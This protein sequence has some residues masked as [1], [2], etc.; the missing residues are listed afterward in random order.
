MRVRLHV[1]GLPCA[2]LLLALGACS[3]G[4][5]GA[6]GAPAAARSYQLVT[7]VRPAAPERYFDA[8]YALHTM[9]AGSAQARGL[10]VTPFPTF[11]K[12]FAI[13]RRTYASDGQ[14]TVFKEVLWKV[15]GGSTFGATTG[16]VM[17]IRSDWRTEITEGGQTHSADFTDGKLVQGAPLPAGGREVDP[18]RLA[19][20]SAARVENGVRLKCSADSCIVDP[21]LVQINFGARP[22][23]AWARIDDPRTALM[24]VPVSLS[25]GEAL[26]PA[27]FRQE[28]V[29]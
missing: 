28:K 12:D 5:A 13:A 14:R 8:A 16:C 24:L 29:Q 18:A 1:L 2:A 27:L 23:K 15:D 7:E 19:A 22:A 25:V 17:T 10:P 20:Y 9:C 3:D 6:G 11:P 4:K 21:D 26:D